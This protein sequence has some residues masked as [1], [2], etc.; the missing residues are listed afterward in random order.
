M[1][2][3]LSLIVAGLLLAV[4][5]LCLAADL[6]PQAKAEIEYLIGN[7]QVSSCQFNRNGSWYSGA[8]AAEHIRKKYDY[9]TGKNKLASS[10]DFIRLAASGSSMS[11]VA[12]KVKCGN[13]EP[14]PSSDWFSAELLAYRQQQKPH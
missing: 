11:G 1:K 10:E 14:Q 5:K 3:F 9:F 6:S 13:A 2:T 8:Q 7:L 4:A 12:Y